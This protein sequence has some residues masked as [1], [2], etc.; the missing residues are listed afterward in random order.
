MLLI[1]SL[2]R[3]KNLFLPKRKERSSAMRYFKWLVAERKCLFIMLFVL[4]AGS[5][6]A[7]A[8]YEAPRDSVG[9]EVIDGKKFILYR[10]EAKETL[11]SIA[12]L[13]GIS[14]AELVKHNPETEAGL[15]I[16]AVLRIP[17]RATQAPADSG[18]DYHVVEKSETL[19][20]IGR[21]YGVTVAQLK[22][23]NNLSTDAISLGDRIKIFG[24]TKAP[25]NAVSGGAGSEA[26]EPEKNVADYSG[27]IVHTVEIKETLY[28][29]ARM[30]DT[31]EDKIKEWNDLSTNNLAVGQK[32]IVGT[33][34]ALPR[35]PE[36]GR[37]LRNGQ[38]DEK[39]KD[40][41][42]NK[43]P[44]SITQIGDPS[45]DELFTKASTGPGEENIRKI[46]ELGMAIVID[47]TVNTKKYLALHRTAPIGTIMQ[48]HNEMNN[49]SV[50]V[51][52][53]GKLPPTG[54]NDK[55][56][57]KLSRKAFDKL[58]AYNEKFPVRLTYV[59]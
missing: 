39:P 36:G 48:V 3:A 52:V 37:I 10:V 25:E 11:Y 35:G 18:D 55:V 2:C 23:W 15:K 9:T 20:S 6:S 30:H 42:Y 56:L 24:Q 4:F 51:R 59:P 40:Y 29:I 28:S 38:Q 1:P 19:Y 47:D 31:T 41:K 43:N 54:D 44:V 49:L 50:F 58:G 22:E 7:F 33:T 46:T 21:K 26:G 8:G 45:Q 14:V 32:L 5:S 13:Y 16:G 12:N 53:V 34:Q 57:I 27:K 17:F